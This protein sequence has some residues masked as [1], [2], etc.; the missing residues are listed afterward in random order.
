MELGVIACESIEQKRQ[1]QGPLDALV[2]HLCLYMCVAVQAPPVRCV[3]RLSPA[4]RII[5]SVP[6]HQ[7]EHCTAPRSWC[8]LRAYAQHAMQDAGSFAAVLFL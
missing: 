6:A 5:G 7:T 1:V 3:P 4:C 8:L 2:L